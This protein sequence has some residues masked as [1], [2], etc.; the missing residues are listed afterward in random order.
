MALAACDAPQQLTSEEV[1]PRFHDPQ[2]V[3]MGAQVYQ[4]HCATCHGAQAEGAPDWR[5][6]DEEGMFPPP[7][8]NG[9]GHAWHHP[10]A[11]LKEMILNGS[12]PG[13]GRMPAWQGKLSVEETEAV[14]EWFMSQW[15][16]PAYVAWYKMQHR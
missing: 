14:I 1:V 6:R 7:P 9:S 5:Y 2:Q 11:W 15:P 13:Q 8:L 12:P 3:A 4:R 16:E 10:R